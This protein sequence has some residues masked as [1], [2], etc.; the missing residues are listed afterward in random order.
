[1]P[2]VPILESAA[3]SAAQNLTAG[4]LDDLVTYLFSLRRQS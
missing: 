1:M 4:E 3:D 2:E